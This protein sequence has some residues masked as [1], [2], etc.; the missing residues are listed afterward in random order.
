[1]A[2][3]DTDPGATDGAGAESRPVVPG[4][5]PAEDLPEWGADRV[6]DDR[7]VRDRPAHRPC[8]VLAVR[9]RDDPVLRHEPDRRLQPD[10]G[11]GARGADD[12]PIGLRADRSRAQVG[13][14]PDPGSRARAARVSPEVVRIPGEAAP[15]APAV[16]VDAG[17]ADRLRVD[18]TKVGPF[19]QVRL[20]EDDGAGRPEP[21]HDRR[22]AGHATAGQREGSRRRLHRVVRRDVVLD[23]DRDA[24]E[25]PADASV[26][27]FPVAS[28]GDREGRRV[29]LDDGMKD[30]IEAAD[31]LE[32]RRGQSD[33]RDLP[34]REQRGE[35]RDR[36][37][38][39]RSGRVLVDGWDQRASDRRIVPSGPGC[40]VA[41]AGPGESND[42]GRLTTRVENLA[43][44]RRTVGRPAPRGCEAGSAAALAAEAVAA[45]DRLAAG[46]AEGDRSLLA[47]G[48]AG[49]SEHLAGT[50]IVSTTTTAAAV[51][52]GATG[53]A[54]GAVA[55]G[56]IATALA[57]AGSLAAGATG[58]AA[59]R[60]GEATLRVEILLGGSEHEFLSTV[61]AG[62]IL[63]VVHENENSSR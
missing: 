13:G 22:V 37:L 53:I 20:S 38:E 7:R 11:T 57:V 59:A 21:R 10:V 24:V 30:G 63:V 28:G 51:A 8:G 39:P 56:A 45:V 31:P 3:V 17:V 49:R 26:P 42:P 6:E 29:R 19:R 48:R 4:Q 1:M 12:R 62:Q 46:R 25:R 14:R 58:R 43:L 34:G 35:L 27:A 60:L 32:I 40:R 50:A 54:A 55:T 18:P 44:V 23:H 16:D 52:A 61:R 5:R 2:P 9:D 41:R 47:A 36:R 33:R 15:G